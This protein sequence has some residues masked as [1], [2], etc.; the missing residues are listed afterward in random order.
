LL[1]HRS[2]DVQFGSCC[3]DEVAAEHYC[4][5]AIVHYGHACL[6]PTPG[7]IPVKFIFGH[8]SFDISKCVQQLT[9]MFD[10]DQSRHVLLFYDTLYFNAVKG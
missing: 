4:C 10:G 5:D 7:R 2:V 9:E 8:K 3:V 6:S 1:I